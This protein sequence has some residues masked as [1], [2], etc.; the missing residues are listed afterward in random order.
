MNLVTG[1]TGFLGSHIAEQLA[2]QGEP[3]RALVRPTSDTSFLRT[4]D[5]VELVVGDLGDRASLRAACQG[6]RRV[7][8]AAA[9]VGEWAP[10]SAFEAAT[11][12]GTRNLLEAASDAGADRFIHISSVSVYG[13]PGGREVLLDEEAPVGCNL[14]RGSFYARSKLEAERLVRESSGLEFVILRPAWI[15][16]PRDR[17]SLPRLV[18]SLRS[19]V[20]RLIGPGDNPLGLVYAANV[21]QAALRAA[22]LQAAAGRTYNLVNP[23]R[24]TQR[25][26][27]DRLAE[28]LDLPRVHGSIPYGL[29]DGVAAICEGVFRALGLSHPPPV[30]RHAVWLLG[31]RVYFDPR[32][33]LEEL[34]WKPLGHEEGFRRTARWLRA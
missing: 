5:G 22:Q 19:R 3:V 10:W 6:V 11:V 23:D 21:A 12:T 16:G 14:R 4:L 13:Y 7:F 34:G 24:I 33:A 31:R 29:A 8:H 2:A 25:E 15:Y 28:M 27:F 32:R 30:T 17:V 26:F 9:Q 1:A 18:R 20:A